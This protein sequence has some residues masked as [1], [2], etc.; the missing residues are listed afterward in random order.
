M[1]P[2]NGT[3]AVRIYGTFT[4]LGGTLIDPGTVQLRLAA[5]GLPGT[6]YTFASG[7]VQ[8][9]GAGVYYY[10]LT[11]ARGGYVDYRWQSFGS[12]VTADPGR[13]FVRYEEVG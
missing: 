9:E 6:T 5:R 1:T 4:N 10:D 11:A 12:V 7:S 13:I 8:R 3:T 2:Y